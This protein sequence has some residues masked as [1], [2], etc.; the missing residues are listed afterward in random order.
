M[1]ELP[2]LAVGHLQ[3]HKKVVVGMDVQ[4]QGVHRGIVEQQILAVVVVQL[5]ELEPAAQ[6]AAA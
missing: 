1:L 5:V 6:A 3:L 4:P 2:D